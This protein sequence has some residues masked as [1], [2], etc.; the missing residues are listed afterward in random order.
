M[1]SGECECNHILL[2]VPALLAEFLDSLA[3]S[4][5]EF[6]VIDHAVFYLYLIRNTTSR[7]AASA[8]WLRNSS[9]QQ[10]IMQ[11]PFA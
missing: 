11:F 10:R 5:E 3:K 1:A 6:G 2:S 8:G 4:F 7:L 9:F